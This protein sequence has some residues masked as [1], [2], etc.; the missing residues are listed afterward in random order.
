VNDV[1]ALPPRSRIDGRGYN[2]WGSVAI[3]FTTETVSVWLRE[4]I[5]P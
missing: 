5:K 2:S 3:Q 4:S 1:I